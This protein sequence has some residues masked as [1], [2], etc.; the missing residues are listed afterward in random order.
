MKNLLLLLALLATFANANESNNWKGADCQQYLAALHAKNITQAR[1]FYNK[2]V[3]YHMLIIHNVT[4]DVLE[5]DKFKGIKNVEVLISNINM[6]MLAGMSFAGSPEYIY[7]TC[8]FRAKE[9]DNPKLTRLLFSG[10]MASK[11]NETI[12]YDWWDLNT[13]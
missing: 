1:F 7:K 8:A 3:E 5:H 2:A 13:D 10:Y 4:M 12:Q 9:G 11:T 6:Q